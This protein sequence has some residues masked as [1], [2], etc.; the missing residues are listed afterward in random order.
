NIPITQAGSLTRPIGEN[1]VT[2]SPPRNLADIRSDIRN[3]TFTTEG[4]DPNLFNPNI[5]NNLV[6]GNGSGRTC[7]I[8][9]DSGPVRNTSP[10]PDDGTR[11][12]SRTSPDERTPE[13]EILSLTEDLGPQPRWQEGMYLEGR[14]PIRDPDGN[15]REAG[16]ELY[17][18]G[19]H[20]YGLERTR[21]NIEAAGRILAEQDI[22]MGVGHLSKASGRTT[23]HSEHQGGKDIDLRFIPPRDESGVAWARSCTTSDPSC[24]DVDNTFQ[25]IKAFIDVDPYGIDRVYVNSRDLRVKVNEYLRDTYGIAYDP[26][27]EGTSSPRGNPNISTAC[28]GHS[29]HIHLSF[30]NN[31]PSPDDLMDQARGRE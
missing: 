26:S 7:P 20:N 28:P 30:K 3:G 14:V 6:S 22:V 21:W 31:G 27:K 24:F 9:T 19:S 13:R 1:D 4:L 29:D 10:G 25:M 23:S 18:D 12:G 2:I 15:E 11:G 8:S 5:V 17:G 16:Y